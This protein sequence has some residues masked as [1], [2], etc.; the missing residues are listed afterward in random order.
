[1][2]HLIRI[3]AEKTLRHDYHVVCSCFV[4]GRFVALGDARS[5]AGLHAMNQK[6]V[7]SAKINDETEKKSATAHMKAGAPPPPPA[8]PSKKK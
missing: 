1:M 6:G 7:N 5:F 2:E 3:H 4:E 8:P